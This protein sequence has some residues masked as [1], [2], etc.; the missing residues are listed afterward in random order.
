ME[1]FSTTFGDSDQ[2]KVA[3]IKIQ[4]FQEGTSSTTFMLLNFNNSHVK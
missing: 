2:E 1:A 3:E 4:D